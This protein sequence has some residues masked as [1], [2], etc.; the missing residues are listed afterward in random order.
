MRTTLAIEDDIL[1]AL[2][3]RAAETGRPLTHVVND[4]LRAGLDVR[5]ESPR[6]RRYR[7]VDL[8][9]IDDLQFL[10]NKAKTQ[11][12]LFHTFAA[13]YAAG[14]KVVLTSDAPPSQL[15]GLEQRLQSR[16]EGGLVVDIE[17]PD[18]ETRLAILEAKTRLFGY[19]LALDLLHPIA[20]QT[21]AN[22]RELEGILH[23]LNLIQKQQNGD[24]SLHQVEQHIESLAPEREPVEP[25]LM[26]KVISD[27]YGI[28]VEDL[29]GTARN[30][31]TSR[32]RQTAMYLLHRDLKLT[33]KATGRLLGGRD[34]KTISHGIRQMQQRLAGE[35]QLV[36]DIMEVRSRLQS[37]MATQDWT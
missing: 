11:E 6:R 18:S 7:E 16:F 4:T 23:R 10:A 14:K 8:L 2:E 12:E 37:T 29:V 13:L 27:N 19:D 31:N 36:R 30:R 17:A 20:F 21:Y 26:L 32:A 22:V 3:A 15:H 24:L 33:L 25:E 34:H 28:R 35:P 9:L 5:A 1:Q